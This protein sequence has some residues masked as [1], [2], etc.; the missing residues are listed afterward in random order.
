MD[1]EEKDRAPT[2]N[3][4][5]QSAMSIVTHDSATE[6]C[7]LASLPPNMADINEPQLSQHGDA[8]INVP[9]STTT[10]GCHPE[11]FT[12]AACLVQCL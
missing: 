4:T 8:I 9:R 12:H 3:E 6:T 11:Y 1:V 2:E 7:H 10:A 5:R